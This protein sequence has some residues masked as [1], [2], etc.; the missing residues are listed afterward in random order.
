MEHFII[1]PGSQEAGC[2]GARIL[3][4]LADCESDCQIGFFF[5]L[6]VQPHVTQKLQSPLETAKG[7]VCK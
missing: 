6:V 3:L 5:E 2:H 4:R 7:L 1:F